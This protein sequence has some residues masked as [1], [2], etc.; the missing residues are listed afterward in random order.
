MA[1]KRPNDQVEPQSLDKKTPK[2]QKSKSFQADAMR[3]FKKNPTGIIGSII[4]SVFIFLAI[5]GPFITPHDPFEMN[6]PRHHE[7]PSIEY[8]L[9]TDNFGRCVLSR[10][11]FGARIS[12]LVGLTVIIF[13]ML[14]GI[15]VGLISGYYGG[16]T[17]SILM[18]FVDAVIAFPGIILALAIMAVRG[19]GLENVI[20]ALSVTGWTT[21]ARLIRSEVLSLREREYVQA[22]R[23]VGFHNL[24]VMLR[25]IL[26][27]CLASIIVYSTMTI[28]V[29]IIAEASL[30]F[31][32]LGAAAQDATWGTQMSMERKYLRYAWWGVTF[33][34]AAI[35]IVVLG[36]NLLG[37]ALRDVLDPRLKD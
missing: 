35:A 1:N 25:H 4:I 2:I 23:G 10:I 14:I 36:F 18:R 22:A 29:V 30:S 37:D 32:G 8:P 11:I 7:P 16:L 19:Q 21:Y 34:G 12:I 13:R 15:P 5:F 3:R 17:E 9:G 6:L 28:A 33:P 24:K 27:N 20:L 31:L 26:P